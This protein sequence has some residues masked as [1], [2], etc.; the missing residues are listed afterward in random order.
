MVRPKLVPGG[1]DKRLR[2]VAAVIAVAAATLAGCST[3]PETPVDHFGFAVGSPLLTTN[4]QTM[5]GASTSSD[6][7]AGRLYPPVFVSGPAGQ[8]IPNR[9]LAMAQLLPGANT[10][11]MYSINPAARY[12]DGVPITCTDFLLAFKAGANPALFR[13]HAPLMQQV[14][15]VD[16]TAGA[17]EFTV[18]FKEHMGARWR[19]LFGPGTVVPSHAISNRLG[20]S[21]EQIVALLQ[22]D[23]RAALMPVADLWNN[24]F[25]LRNFDPD[26]QVSAGPYR[27]ESVG[28]NGEVQLVRNEHFHGDAANIDRVMMWP[29]NTDLAKANESRSVEVADLVGVKDVTWVD[30]QDPKNRFVV[31][32][33]QGHLTE[34]LSLGT[35]GVFETAESRRAFAACIAQNDIAAVSSQ[36]SGVDVTP[37]TSRLTTAGEPITS[38]LAEQ[39]DQHLPVNIAE[40]EKLRGKTVRVGY[41]GPD[42]RKQAMV[43][44]IARSCEP[45]GITVVDASSEETSLED[46]S[47]KEQ[48]RGGVRDYE[49]T[50]DAFLY[51]ADPHQGYGHVDGGLDDVEKLRATE[52]QLWDETDTIPLAAQPRTIVYD[53]SIANVVSNT[54]LSGIG[55]NMERWVEGNPQ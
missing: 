28:Q 24:G 1:V 22:S 12:S 8:M 44:A 55:W 7:L 32:H 30:R 4:A 43:A 17:R 47:R 36:E 25:D 16:C 40:A 54:S 45:A 52:R 29:L 23:N 2:K 51:A 15:R 50:L 27:I 53:K 38:Q 37:I 11:V 9:D 18:V 6:A 19:Q 21:E 41:S 5:E 42:P 39:N 31:E 13:S 34:M 46:V 35:A 48:F 49:G 33:E 3:S 14:E 10:Q 20:L 26:L